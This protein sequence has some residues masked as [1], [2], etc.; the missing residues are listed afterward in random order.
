MPCSFP[1]ARARA[2]PNSPRA[3][4]TSWRA[5]PS[6]WNSLLPLDRSDL[7]SSLHRLG[8]VFSTDYTDDGVRVHAML[9]LKALPA[10]QPYRHE[11]AGAAGTGAAKPPVLSGV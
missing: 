1:P 5:A 10:V 6:A 3:W 2:S 11:A 7:L 9:P 8:Q 4:P